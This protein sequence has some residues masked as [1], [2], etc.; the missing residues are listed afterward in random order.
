VAGPCGNFTRFPILLLPEKRRQAPEAK[1]VLLRRRI[2]YTELGAREILR[3]D[4]YENYAIIASPENQQIM[5]C[6]RKSFHG[7]FFGTG[8]LQRARTPVLSKSAKEYSI[9][10][11]SLDGDE[12]CI[13]G[14]SPTINGDYKA[15]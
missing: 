1:T 2:L 13:V 11:V 10:S 15:C 3:R 9:H 4:I 8:I 5:I 14:A 12:F 6:V 7:R